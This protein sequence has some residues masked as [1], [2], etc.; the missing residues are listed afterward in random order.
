MNKI[1]LVL[2]QTVLLELEEECL[3]GE[4]LHVGSDRSF[5]RLSNVRDMLTKESYGIQTYYN[6]EIRNIQANFDERPVS[7]TTKRE[8][9]KHV[10]F[11]LSLQDLFIHEIMLEP[12]YSSCSNYLQSLS[13]NPDFISSLTDLRNKN[14]EAIEAVAP[15]KLGIDVELLDVPEQESNRS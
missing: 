2:G 10:V 9:A 1:D 15:V 6:S 3:L 12:F 11:L 14:G 4:L 7:D 8:A 13:C 5:I